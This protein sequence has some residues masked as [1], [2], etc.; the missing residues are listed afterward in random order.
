MTAG[1][2]IYIATQ[3]I[4]AGTFETFAAIARKLH[5]A[6]R[7]SRN[8]TLAGTITLTGGCGGMGG[9]QP[10][11]VTSSTRRGLKLWTSTSPA[12]SDAR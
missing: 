4:L 6:G 5:A 10:L 3:G 12:L 8:S 7:L 9:A 11:A 2:W 1:S